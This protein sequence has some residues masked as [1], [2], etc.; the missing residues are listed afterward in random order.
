MIAQLGRLNPQE[1]GLRVTVNTTFDIEIAW[2]TAERTRL[3]QSLGSSAPMRF[4]VTSMTI[5][6]GL[7]PRPERRG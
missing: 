2:T 3:G 6:D 1:L 4:G 7:V 5:S